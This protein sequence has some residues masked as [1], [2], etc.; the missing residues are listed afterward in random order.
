M[1]SENTIEKFK[2]AT[3]IVSSLILTL[4]DGDLFVYLVRAPFPTL[5]KVQSKLQGWDVRSLSLAGRVILA[6]SILLEIEHM[7]RQFVWRSLNS[8]KDVALVNWEDVQVLRAKYRVAIGIPETLSRSTGLLVNPIPRHASLDLDYSLNDMVAN[9]G[10]WNLDLFRL[11]LSE[12]AIRK[13]IGIPL[14][15][16]TA[17]VNKIIW[18]GTRTGSFSVKSAYGK[19][20]ECSWNQKEDIWKFKGLQKGQLRN[21]FGNRSFA[22][23]RLGVGNT[24]GSVRH[25]DGSAAAGGVVRN[26]NGEWIT[27]FNRFLGSYSMFEVELQLGG[28]YD[29]PGKFYRRVQFS[30][31]QKDSSTIVSNSPLEY[32]LHTQRRESGSR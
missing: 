13:I 31:D 4:S 1:G 30:F 29:H 6:Q 23:I 16:S 26:R 20:W 32:L 15:H 12:T 14:P 11:W 25:D 18:G 2:G 21:I 10:T 24:V 19:I 27:G 5:D 28:A 8:G 9:D 17:R 22:L 3:V 7:V